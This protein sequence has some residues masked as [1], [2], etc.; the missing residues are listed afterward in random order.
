VNR[1]GSGWEKPD[2]NESSINSAQF[3]IPVTDASRVGNARR[4]VTELAR[5][6]GFDRTETGKVAI[7]VTETVGN[8]AKH[9]VQGELL[10]RSLRYGDI[11][12][13]EI[14]ALDRGPGITEVA[15]CIRDGYS[16]TGSPGTGLGAVARLSTLFDIHSVPGLGTA[17]CAHLFSLPLPGKPPQHEWVIGA[18]CLPSPGEELCGD[19]WA[20][21][22]RPGRSLIIVADGLG[23][24]PH[25]SDASR[26][27]V[28]IFEEHSNI[29]PAAILDKTHLALHG[30]RGAAIGIAELDYGNCLVKYVGVGNIGGVI[31][32]PEGHRNMVS[33]NG[34][35]GHRIRKIQEFTYPLHKEALLVMHSDGLATRWSLD[36]YPGLANRHPS[37]IA[38]VLYRDYSR[39]RDDVTV[40]VAR[41]GEKK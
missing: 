7:V 6:I 29:A 10:Y 3:A 39:G 41:L 8:L 20:K 1:Y 5:N 27:A 25:A 4:Q 24:G 23:H 40:V 14:L 37:L 16:T 12:G 2:M 28:R 11:S 35:V 26:E 18:V 31:L 9:S 38:G 30:T 32:S 36:R 33:H 13:I 34:I 19:A 21:E 15:K 22:E 17:L